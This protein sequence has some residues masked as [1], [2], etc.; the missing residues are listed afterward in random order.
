[1]AKY[2]LKNWCFI[3]SHIFQ[4]LILMANIFNVSSF[5]TVVTRSWL[6]ASSLGSCWCSWW[7]VWSSGS[8]NRN[9][10]SSLFHAFSKIYIQYLHFSFLFIFLLCFSLCNGYT[11]IPVVCTY[12]HYFYVVLPYL[13]YLLSL[14]ILSDKPYIQWWCYSPWFYGSRT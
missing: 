3:K 11:I 6:F 14:A 5:N 9:T 7:L 4:F 12:Y 1:M 13:I 2:F 10:V 8:L